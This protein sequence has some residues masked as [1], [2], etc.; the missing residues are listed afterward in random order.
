[1]G[2]AQAQLSSFELKSQGTALK[3]FVN[4]LLP[5]WLLLLLLFILFLLFFLFFYS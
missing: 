2:E 5:I 4:H 3:R 1:M